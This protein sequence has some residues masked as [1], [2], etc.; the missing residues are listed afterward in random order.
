MDP[1][2]VGVFASGLW[3]F[4]EKLIYGIPRLRAD[5]KQSAAIFEALDEIKAQLQAY[6][7]KLDE[8]DSSFIVSDDTDILERIIGCSR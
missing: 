5:R 6:Q 2:L 3:S 8:K 4:G 7:D 1:I